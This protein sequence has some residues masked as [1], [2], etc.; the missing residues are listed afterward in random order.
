[1]I[2]SFDGVIGRR[3]RIRLWISA[4]ALGVVCSL[5]WAPGASGAPEPL[6]PQ[7]G[8]GTPGGTAGQLN[9]PFDVAIDAAGNLYVADQSNNRISVFT[10]EGSFLRAFGFDVIPGGGTGFEIC[11][12]SCKAGVAGN[13]AGQLSDPPGVATDCRGAVYV[14]DFA[15]HRIQRFGEPGTP[16][17]PCPTP[18]DTPPGG[19]PSNEFTIGKL[20]RNTDKGTAKL[21]V[22]L[23]GA[24]EL[25]LSGGK[26]KARSKQANGAGKVKL[27]VKAKGKAKEKLAD[28]G[29][30]KVKLAVTFTPT[31]GD[32]NTE[33]KKAKLKLND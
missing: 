3:P 5:I 25:E 30:V 2:I 16:L 18:G 33:T 32:P 28:N 14:A 31:G 10:P 27:P 4:A 20:K 22:E 24:G 6:A 12:A 7:Y 19:A 23:P 29:S 26:V 21:T 9:G 11:T 17:P 1:M 8:V 13:G 15:N